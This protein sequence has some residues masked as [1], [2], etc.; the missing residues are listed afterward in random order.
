[1]VHHQKS[2]QADDQ[3]RERDD[4]GNRAAPRGALPPRALERE[5]ANAPVVDFISRPVL[6]AILAAQPGLGLNRFG[7]R[8]AWPGWRLRWWWRRRWLNFDI[9]LG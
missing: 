4:A 2:R 7:R 8:S 1:M 6:V 5:R 9:G 3:R